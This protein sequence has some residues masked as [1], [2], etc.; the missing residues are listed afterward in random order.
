MTPKDFSSYNT[1]F[2]YFTKWKREGVFK[3][4]MDMLREMLRVSLGREESPSLGIMDSRSTKTTQ[5]VD[6]ERGVDGNK[7]VKG[8]K[9]QVVVDTLGLPMAVSVHQANIHDSKGAE[10]ALEKLAHKFPRLRKIIA[11]GGYRGDGL[12]EKVRTTLGCRLEVVLRPDESPKK[13]NVIPLRWIAKRSVAWLCN[14]RRITSDYES[15]S[16]SSEAMIQIDFAKIIF[17]KLSN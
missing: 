7:K 6:K 5:H 10:S 3:D 2:Y 15:Y 16:E 4:V 12:K 14:F 11:A 1:E 17:D 13:F 9:D 8:R